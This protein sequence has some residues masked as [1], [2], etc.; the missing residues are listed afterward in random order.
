MQGDNDLV[1]L[2]TDTDTFSSWAGFLRD[3]IK[4]TSSPASL[5]VTLDLGPGQQ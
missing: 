3:T 2:A 1:I 4:S 5:T